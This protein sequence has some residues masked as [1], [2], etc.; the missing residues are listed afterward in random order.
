[1]TG[2]SPS[3][4]PPSMLEREIRSQS[5]WL[6]TDIDGS[7][8]ATRSAYRRLSRPDVTHIIVAARGSSDNAARYA[9]YLWGR[10]LRWSTHMAAPSLYSTQTP[11]RLSGAAVVG[12]SQ[13]GQSPDIVGVLAAARDQARP[14]VAIT[15][16]PTSPLAEIAD[17]VVDLAVGPELSLAATKTFTASLRAVVAIASVAGSRELRAGLD[18]L[19]E[20]FDQTVSM[21]L[22]TTRPLV[23][24]TNLDDPAGN[25]LTV[26]G[27]G[28]GHATAAEA[29]L[30][31]R[32]IARLR[33]EAYSAPDLLH[34]PVAAN[35]AGSAVL[36][37]ASPGQPL[38]YWSDL[39][40]RLI[41]DGVR[42]T[43]IVSG[44]QS[45]LTAHLLHELPDD[46][47]AWLFDFV[48]VPFGQVAALRLGLAKGLDVD[49][50]RGLTKVTLTT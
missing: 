20:L 13:S 1:V 47:P 42:V 24:L 46:L 18:R 7:G 26:V 39:A 43:A 32:E 19:P 27:R 36:I 9:Q 4:S 35:G 10:A 3:D 23:E 45:R 41:A 12:I 30:K 29:A 5:R 17:V 28:T 50:P 31:I 38:P 33:A 40:D 22:E 6:L 25:L 44:P 49:R 34:G 15:N 16:D 14:T 2:P 48:A 8:Q 21:A 11:P 37:I